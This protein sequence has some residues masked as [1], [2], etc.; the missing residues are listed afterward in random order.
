MQFLY[1]CGDVEGL[2]L[3]QLSDPAF[4]AP[5]QKH[6][7]CTGIGGA[8][9]AVADIDGKEFKEAAGRGLSGGGN[10]CR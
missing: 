1:I 4:F 7:G 3:A 10:Q 5:A 9:I 8:G 6:P 2:H